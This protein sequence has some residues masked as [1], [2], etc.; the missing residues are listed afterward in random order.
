MYHLLSNMRTATLLSVF[1][2]GCFS[3][4]HPHSLLEELDVT[5]G[6]QKKVS[7][8][9]HSRTPCP[10]NLFRYVFPRGVECKLSS[11][12]SAYAIDIIVQASYPK[13]R[14]LGEPAFT[15]N[16]QQSVCRKGQVSGHIYVGKISRRC[17][18]LTES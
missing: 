15:S 18:N 12:S 7:A 1:L 14:A 13:P 11:D 5:W 4:F 3:S 16:G 6:S 10:A 17:P 9:L 8:S 2:I